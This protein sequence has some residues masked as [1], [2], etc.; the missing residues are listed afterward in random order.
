[1]NMNI[2]TNPLPLKGDIYLDKPKRIITAKQHMDKDDE[3]LCL[4][5]WQP[6]ANNSVPQPSY[7]TNKDLKDICPMILIEY[8]ESRLK[9][10]T[11]SKK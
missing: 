10:P 7:Y 11:P 1:M 9:F 4:V 8:Y 3:I 5:E 6:R 2:N